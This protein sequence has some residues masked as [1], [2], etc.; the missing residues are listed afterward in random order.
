MVVGLASWPR[1]YIKAVVGPINR[2]YFFV[3][4]IVGLAI[5]GAVSTER[6]IAAGFSGL[7]FW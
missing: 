5:S 3:S 1:F 2:P 6:E 4:A 7:F